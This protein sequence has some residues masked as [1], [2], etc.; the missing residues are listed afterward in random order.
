MKLRKGEAMNHAAT[1]R[2]QR[3]TVTIHVNKK[4]EVQHAEPEYFEISKSNQ[5]EVLW[6][7]SDPDVYFTV[8]F[9]DGSPFYESQFSSDFPASGLVRRDI[10]PDLQRRYKYTVRA[11]GAVLDPGGV[12]TK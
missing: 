3:K 5:E 9:E 8:E 1:G 10:L 11:G 6:Q 7:S 12:I 4:G 2:A